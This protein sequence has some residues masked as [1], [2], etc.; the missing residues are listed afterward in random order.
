VGNNLRANLEL[1]AQIAIAVAV[2]A[3]AGIL[4]KRNVFPASEVDGGL[5]PSIE[6]GER[7]NV[8]N[9]DWERNDKSLVFFLKMGCTHCATAAP[10]YRQ[11]IEEASKRNVGSL[12]ILPNS[13]D[14]ARKYLQDLNLPIETI[15]T[16]D[17]RS[18]KIAGTPTVLFVDKAGIVRGRWLGFRPEREKEMRDELVSLFEVKADH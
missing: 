12:A 2:L 11:L 4:V 18:Y 16:G 17:L 3:V 7:L 6:V 5:P 13:V 9:I 10:F 8:P 1:G 14:E 15:L